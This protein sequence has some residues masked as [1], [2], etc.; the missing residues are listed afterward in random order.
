MLMP[1]EFVII[2]GLS[3]AG[4][5]SALH[6]LEDLGFFCVDNL[7]SVLLP[8]FARLLP[9][10]REA[11]GV[12]VVVDV[13]GGEFFNQAVEAFRKLE[14]MGVRY[15]IVYLDALDE[16]LI[17]RFKETRRRHPLA[18]EGRVAEGLVEERR[19]LEP[20]RDRAHIV[21]DT[22]HLRPADLRRR[23]AELFSHP[24]E[25]LFLYLVSFGYKFGLPLD[26]DLVVDV[27]FLPNPHYVPELQ[28]LP[29]TDRRVVRYVLQMEAARDFLR[30]M[31]SFLRFLLP[32]YLAEGKSQLTIALGCT[33]GRHRS[34][35]LAEALG[36]FLRRL[37]YRVTVEHRDLERERAREG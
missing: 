19:R 23:L 21:L 11:P 33:G 35:V 6:F 32:H 36:R 17:R 34:V 16:V 4:K 9:R 1:P 8:E 22:T 10:E 3:G 20:W 30:R 29:G 13:R 15:R 18:P 37:G 28:P 26:A 27:R 31:K 2:T 12:A 5:T 14:E 7:P 25:P 24:L